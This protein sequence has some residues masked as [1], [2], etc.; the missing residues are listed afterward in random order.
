MDQI[1]L[2]GVGHRYDNASYAL[3]PLDMT[4]EAGR[5]YAL[6]GPSGCGK[7]TMLNIISGLIKPSDGRIRLGSRDVTEVGTAARNIAQVFQF[8]V[9]YRSKTIG[10]NLAFPLLCRNWSRVQIQHRVDEIADLLGLSSMLNR[11]AYDLGA[12]E[13][14]L[15]SLGRGLVR[16]DVAALLMDEP[17]TVIDPQRKFE[18]RRKI[19][20]VIEQ[21]RLTVVYVTHDQNEAMTF[22]HEILVMSAGKVVQR[23]VAEELFERLRTTYVGQFIGF[24]AMNFLDVAVVPGGLRTGEVFIPLDGYTPNSLPDNSRIQIGIRPEHILLADSNTSDAI[25]ATLVGIQDCGGVRILEA[26]IGTSMTRIK[27]ARDARTTLGTVG[28]IL[29]RSKIRLYCNGQLVQ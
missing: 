12:D 8:P 21:S 18:L 7:T 27:V 10:Q 14:Q 28:V 4:F 20:S 24:P 2:V 1:E 26:R 23:G 13:K 17:L 11:P 29:Q 19:K 5:T 6:L 9:I 15:I 3:E 25:D 16:N 22:A